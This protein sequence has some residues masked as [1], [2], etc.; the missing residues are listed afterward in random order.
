[1]FAT[2]RVWTSVIVFTLGLAL[3]PYPVHAADAVAK[4]ESSKVKAMGKYV[5]CR[6]KMEARAALKQ[7]PADAAS[8]AK[9][10]TKFLRAWDKAEV[11]AGGLCASPPG[12]DATIADA[13]SAVYSDWAAVY[14]GGGAPDICAGSC[15]QCSIDLGMCQSDLGS[16]QGDLLTCQGGETQCMIDLGACQS[17]LAA[18]QAQSGGGSAASGQTTSFVA[19]D[20]GDLM[21]GAPL[22]YV[23]NGDGT[24][25]DLNTTLTWEKKVSLDGIGDAFALHDADNRYPWFGSCSLSG[26][27]C[28]SD[29]DC[30]VAE[31]C[32][33]G[34]LQTPSPN[35]LTIFEWVALMNSSVFAG[36]NDW[37]VPNVRELQSIVDYG[38]FSPSV[39]LALHEFGCGVGCSDITDPACSCTVSAN[40]WSSSTFASS[41]TGA[42]GVNFGSG[43]V[44]ANAKTSTLFVRAVRGGS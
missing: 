43:L 4:C 34:D 22:A 14:V 5:G 42:W 37:R 21:A 18:C 15:G 40:Y 10:A 3:R 31:S 28:G 6:T 7:V 33:V 12:A 36:F 27:T 35:G 41:S 38:T 11:R 19:A 1:M 8:L 44:N 29:V 23:D 2:M 17:D 30:P 39:G 16:C 32:D 25:T 26:A 20:D 13:T 9:C 24:V